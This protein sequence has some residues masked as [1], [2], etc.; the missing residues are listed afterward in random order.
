MSC[1]AS[2]PFK[3]GHLLAGEKGSLLLYSHPQLKL[4]F[5]AKPAKGIEI[6]YV[7]QTV[8]QKGN[9]VVLPLVSCDLG[10]PCQAL[11]NKVG[12]TSAFLS[13]Q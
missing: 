5:T 2:P 10:Q 7:S 1:P 13:Y 12:V 8:T 6:N 11:H 4:S 9:Y 3:Q